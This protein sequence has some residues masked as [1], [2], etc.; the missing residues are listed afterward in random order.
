[1][2]AGALDVTVQH[3]ATVGSGPTAGQLQQGWVYTGENP[4]LRFDASG[5]GSIRYYLE[6]ANDSIATLVGNQRANASAPLSSITQY[7]YDGFR[8]PVQGSDSPSSNAGGDFG[9]H[10]AWLDDGTKLYEMRA[11]TYD[12]K[13]R[14][15]NISPCR[16]FRPL[17]TYGKICYRNQK[18]DRDRV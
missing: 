16:L 17:L 7:K 9:F 18:G 3:L 13:N 15:K 14:P 5:A 11:S 4:L 8:L 12:A 10:A 2:G 6:D 1:M